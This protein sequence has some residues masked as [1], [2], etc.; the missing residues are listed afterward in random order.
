MRL[1]K[2]VSMWGGVFREAGRSSAGGD[3]FL[4]E[5]TITSEPQLRPL[6]AA[7]GTKAE[8]KL[9][10]ARNKDIT[11]ENSE[12]VKQF[13]R[14]KKSLFAKIE[15]LNKTLGKI[16]AL[17]KN[18]HCVFADNRTEYVRLIGRLVT[19]I[20]S[21]IALECSLPERAEAVAA[22]RKV[23]SSLTPIRFVSDLCALPNLDDVQVNMPMAIA[24]Y[25]AISTNRELFN[26]LFGGLTT[27]VILEQ[28]LD[29]FLGTLRDHITG[30]F[31][32]IHQLRAK[33]SD[34]VTPNPFH[35]DV[36]MANTARKTFLLEVKA[37]K[38]GPLNQFGTAAPEN[39]PISQWVIQHLQT[40]YIDPA[41]S[42]KETTLTFFS[43][44]EKTMKLVIKFI[45]NSLQATADA[46]TPFSVTDAPPIPTELVNHF[47]YDVYVHERAASPVAS[48][49]SSP[50]R[51]ASQSSMADSLIAK[52]FIQSLRAEIAAWTRS[53]T[54]TE[55]PGMTRDLYLL[56]WTVFSEVASKK[57]AVLSN[58]GQNVSPRPVRK[59]GSGDSPKN[60]QGAQG[61]SSD[62]ARSATGGETPRT[63]RKM[64]PGAVP[65]FRVPEPGQ[66]GQPA[67]GRPSAAQ[68]A[69]AASAAHSE[70]PSS[71]KSEK[72]GPPRPAPKPGKKP[73]GPH[74]RGSGGP[75]ATAEPSPQMGIFVSDASEVPGFEPP[76]RHTGLGAP[77]ARRS[78]NRE[79]QISNA[80]L[81]K[82][83]A[84][85]I[86]T[87]HL[88][89]ADSVYA[90]LTQ[91]HPQIK[92][93]EGGM[94]L[95]DALDLRYRLLFDAQNQ[96]STFRA[97]ANG[98][99]VGESAKPY[100][101]RCKL[102]DDRD[103]FVTSF[104]DRVQFIRRECVT[105][106][107]MADI[108][109]RARYIDLRDDIGARLSEAANQLFS[110]PSPAPDEATV[111]RTTLIGLKSI[112][113]IV[114]QKL[115]EFALSPVSLVLSFNDYL[116]SSGNYRLT[117]P[118]EVTVSVMNNPA[119]A[120]Q[121]LF[122]LF[123][124]EQAFFE[125]FVPQD[126]FAQFVRGSADS[127][128]IIEVLIEIMSR[129]RE[130]IG[131]GKGRLTDELANTL[132]GLE[133]LCAH[134]ISHILQKK[135]AA[136]K[137]YEGFPN[138]D[139]QE[140]L[141]GEFLSIWT[142]AGSSGDR[143]SY[144]F[145]EKVRAVL[146]EGFHP[147][148]NRPGTLRSI[149]ST[150]TDL[151]DAQAQILTLV[152]EYL[153]LNPWPSNSLNPGIA[154]DQVRFGQIQIGQADL[155]SLNIYFDALSVS[156]LPFCL[157]TVGLSALTVA[158]LTTLSGMG[159]DT[160]ILCTMLLEVAVLGKWKLFKQLLPMT[161]SGQV[162]LA[163]TTEL[164]FSKVFS[165]NRSLIDYLF[166]IEPANTIFE[167]LATLLQAK[168]KAILRQLV[169]DSGE[170]SDQRFA[171]KY[172]SWSDNTKYCFRTTLLHYFSALI[173]KRDGTL[174]GDDASVINNLNLIAQICDSLPE[175]ELAFVKRQIGNGL[176]AVN[177]R[178]LAQQCFP[179][180][181]LPESQ[182]APEGN[183]W[184]VPVEFSQTGT[185]DE[186]TSGSWF[187]LHLTVGN[188]DEDSGRFYPS[189]P[190]TGLKV[191]AEKALAEIQ[192]EADGVGARLLQLEDVFW[193]H[194][195][196][197]LGRL[198]RTF[199]DPDIDP[200]T[201]KA[202]FRKLSLALHPDSTTK[203]IDVLFD[204]AC[205]DEAKSRVKDVFTNVGRLYDALK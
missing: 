146:N 178:S 92:R 192:R 23:L 55:I 197:S 117:R 15:D 9:T 18:E 129:V 81:A 61:D 135:L 99:R 139:G 22:A 123:P 8:Q 193:D 113:S 36:N 31:D 130:G 127:L 47:D 151:T 202:I 73:D 148:Y 189:I 201:K 65:I 5:I 19:K 93:L 63:A 51:P 34:A 154:D 3:R 77:A 33:L 111:L 67:A 185:I 30:R 102:G 85:Y 88:K 78:F 176:I 137:K 125:A 182:S 41:E 184:V 177:R 195:E 145:Y 106:L 10:K 118:T 156:T 136:G 186:I 204:P 147:E 153:A 150:S 75:A 103:S 140:R 25:D 14:E 42:I 112:L 21:L 90:F 114:D 84:E 172:A 161:R 20:D 203:W 71:P 74:S 58:I 198:E 133:W 38:K 200:S 2:M 144:E 171:Q 160:V 110:D 164:L 11:S 188:R 158:E 181:D 163:R 17:K 157:P 173:F 169:T 141:A 35:H 96:T 7:G 68:P 122:S 46:G 86:A 60:S 43:G 4:L 124:E 57:R 54:V 62:D 16:G 168:F 1:F 98:S 27:P 64:P 91:H 66:P 132:V 205:R 131:A 175:E 72:P 109:K 45:I 100:L 143:L 126:D 49:D 128:S 105:N 40:V 187:G 32:E 87:F 155:V 13:E 6:E 165:G 191:S 167:H 107:Q 52:R 152:L 108:Q 97:W 170:A 39:S 142:A 28:E 79:P 121:N 76:K 119:L 149:L 104:V 115:G 179:G 59:A 50:S 134:R 162:D 190:L 24:V 89:S 199:N 48:A 69:A 82:A 94:A 180:V 83:V 138:L 44:Y 101:V 183:K 174:R 70:N 12:R 194:F 120:V 29:R 116:L 53:N 37:L 95:I 166:E 80:D 56:F 196:A 159:Y 26:S